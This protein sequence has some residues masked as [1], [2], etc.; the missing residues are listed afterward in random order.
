MKAP[1]EPHGP[2][3][4]PPLFRTS[5][6]Q[7]APWP[8]LRPRQFYGYGPEWACFRDHVRVTFGI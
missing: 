5:A 2:R 7:T 4:W 3:G 8:R 6:V 1:R